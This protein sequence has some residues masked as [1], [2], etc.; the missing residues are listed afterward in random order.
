MHFRG[1][2][3]PNSALVP[4]PYD[5]LK[6][7]TCQELFEACLLVRFYCNV[8]WSAAISREDRFALKAQSWLERKHDAGV[9]ADYLAFCALH[10]KCHRAVRALGTS[11][12]EFH[13]HGLRTMAK[14][15]HCLGGA[16]WELGKE[17][18][19]PRKMSSLKMLKTSSTT[20]NSPPQTSP[21]TY[22]VMNFL[23]CQ[24]LSPSRVPWARLR[25]QGEVGWLCCCS[26]RM[27]CGG[28]A[29]SSAWRSSPRPLQPAAM[30]RH[31]PHTPPPSQKHQEI[32]VPEDMSGETQGMG[33]LGSPLLPAS[34]CHRSICL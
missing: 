14:D 32:E 16:L 23:Q 12:W 19:F 10:G 5:V 7:G 22:Y 29:A 30:K 28:Q 6:F 33:S 2:I 9:A 27:S 26:L 13:H 11:S 18:S 15:L 34:T 8:N 31:T 24:Q 1:V 25:D 20:K 4:W 21:E 17:M 3:L